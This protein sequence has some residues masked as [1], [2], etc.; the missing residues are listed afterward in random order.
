[1]S[2]IGGL[3]GRLAE[4]GLDKAQRSRL[5]VALGGALGAGARTAGARAV[6][7]GRWL[8]DVL[9]EQ[10]APRI[11]V[12]DLLTLRAHHGNLSGD[13]LAEDLVRTASRATAAVGAAAGTI[14]AA[15]LAAP[16]LLLTAPVLLAAQTLV[17]IA[18][19]VKLVAELHVVYGR[20]PVGS[21]AQVT[22]A[23]LTSW[24][25]RRAVSSPGGP[26]RPEL[27][28][29]LSA[30]VR[31]QLRR[32]VA[33]RLGRNLSSLAPLLAGAVAAAELNRRDTRSVGAAILGG[34]R[35]QD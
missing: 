33:R 24:A 5:L 20:A 6:V 2:D 11:P 3:V 35:H 23:L 15:E 28:A 25:S 12:R 14:T 9:T 16:P 8:T 30:A 26:G 31:Q 1:M 21:R 19:E 13:Q 27:A 10:V 17:V 34:L 29:A 4:D 22:G 18:I 7:S 32:R